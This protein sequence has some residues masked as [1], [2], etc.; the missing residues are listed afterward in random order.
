MYFPIDYYHFRNY[1]NISAVF[2]SDNIVSIS[3]SRKRYE[4]ESDLASYPSFPV[5]F[6][7]TS[8]CGHL[9]K[10]PGSKCRVA[11]TAGGPK[12]QLQGRADR[13]NCPLMCLHLVSLPIKLMKYVARASGLEG[14]AAMAQEIEH[15]HLSIRGLVTRAPATPL[16]KDEDVGA[17]QEG[18]SG[19]T[20]RARRP[21]PRVMGP[22][23]L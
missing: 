2:V 4:N 17:N 3:F 5:V 23:W 1:R 9:Q 8:V 21:N 12:R 13:Q 16:T 7:P 10:T 6:I 20:K 18:K 22:A 11:L 15:T 19:L 14:Q